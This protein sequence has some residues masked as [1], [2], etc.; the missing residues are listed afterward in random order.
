MYKKIFT[1]ILSAALFAGIL[2]ISA[3]ATEE[4]PMEKQVM[5]Q[6]AMKKDTMMKDDKMMKDEGMK[7]KD[8]MMEKDKMAK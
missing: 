3:C 2:G 8:E 7:K 5:D 1:G 6:G 4:T